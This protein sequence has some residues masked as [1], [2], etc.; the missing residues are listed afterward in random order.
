MSKRLIA[1]FII[2]ASSYVSADDRNAVYEVTAQPRDDY[3]VK[4]NIIYYRHGNAGMVFELASPEVVA[5]YYADRGARQ[6][7]NPFMGSPDLGHATIFLVTLINRTNGN[8]TFTPGYVVLKV[9]DEASFPLDFAML[10]SA[11]EAYPPNLHRILEKSIFHSPEAVRPG[12]IVSKFLF[13][14]PL[15]RKE[16]DFRLEID[17][18]YFEDHE[19]RTRFHY[20][21]RKKE[22]GD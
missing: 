5:R 9:G 21:I 16:T 10:Y 7:G 3:E 12:Q 17:Y 4:D 6:V 14:P 1:I 11:L 19:V 2:L 13:Y 18:L 8:L 15:P 22:S 20:T